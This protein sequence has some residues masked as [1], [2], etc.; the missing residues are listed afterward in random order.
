MKEVIKVVSNISMNTIQTDITKAIDLSFMTDLEKDEMIISIG[1]LIME[2][3][4]LRLLAE[5][6]DEQRESLDQ[7]MET[8][9]SS[10]ILFKHLLEH[11]KSFAQI[12]E[13]EKN[14]FM[15]EASRVFSK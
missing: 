14:N 11:H 4:L 15:E 13:E 5:L 7:F 2:A 1:D 3:A 10:E 12:I 8:N 9:P 6:T